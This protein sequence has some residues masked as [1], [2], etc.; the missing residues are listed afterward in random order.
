MAIPTKP[1]WLGVR[2]SDPSTDELNRVGP[3]A[4]WFNSTEKRFKWWDGVAIEDLP[5]AIKGAYSP[6]ITIPIGGGIVTVSISASSFGLSKLLHVLDCRV[7]RA[8]PV[9]PDVYAPSYG[10]NATGDAV[11]IT[12]AAGSGTTL[13]TYVVVLG[14]P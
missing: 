9:V 11:G 3:G 1:K 10:V 4:F 14:Q 12:L 8:A 5:V 13:Y 2:D 7:Y 6:A